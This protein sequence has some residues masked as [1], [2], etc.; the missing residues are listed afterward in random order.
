VQSGPVYDLIN[1]VVLEEM[2][3]LGL[4]CNMLVAVGGT[5][6]I[7]APTYPHQGLPGG[8][9]PDL[10]V[11]LAGLSDSTLEMWMGIEQPEDP[12]VVDTVFPTIGQFYDTISTAFASYSQPL[13]TNGQIALTVFVPGLKP[14]AVGK[15][16]TVKDAQNAIAL[17]KEQGEGTSTSPDAPQTF[18]DEFAHYYRFGEILNG[19]ELVQVDGQWEYAGPEIELPSCHPVQQVP[20][21]GYPA[22]SYPDVADAMQAFDTRYAK[23][24]GQLEAA[25]SGGG[26]LGPAIA[27]MG[28][29]YGLAKP[30]VTTQL[31]DGSGN[32]GPDFVPANATSGTE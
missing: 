6:Q 28:S 30:I 2:L 21:G 19:H 24:I 12:V 31:P 4:A 10:E 20:A 17:I 3:H 22:S 16:A 18:G 15:L 11:F 23:L 27:T 26:S 25:W 8:V 29:L 14:E 1:S 13:V 7:T 5:P 32:F 9:L